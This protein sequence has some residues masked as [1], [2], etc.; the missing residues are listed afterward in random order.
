M[1]A[2]AGLPSAG[3]RSHAFPFSTLL[4]P[5]NRFTYVT[6]GAILLAALS[7]LIPIFWL[8]HKQLNPLHS[9]YLGILMFI[10]FW[11]LVMAITITIRGNQASDADLPKQSQR[12]A[13][14]A[15]CWL[16]TAMSSLSWC[17]VAA[18]VV[19]RKRK[20]APIVLTPPQDESASESDGGGP[21][22]A[23]PI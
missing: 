23:L 8:R 7:L 15:F 3:S 20:A 4:L 17:V 14:I 2:P 21:S 16:G 11:Q 6:T 12:T 5:T 19:L 22:Y 13:A 9:L 10:W 18:D 1:V